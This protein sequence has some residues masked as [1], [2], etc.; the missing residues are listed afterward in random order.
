[1]IKGELM[2][3]EL[4]YCP[5]AQTIMDR[6]AAWWSGGILDRPIVTLGVTQ[7][8]MEMPRKEHDSVRE[9][10]FDY[11]HQIACCEAF[12]RQCVRVGDALPVFF[13]NLGPEVA[14]TLFGADLEFSEESSWAKPIASSCREILDIE[15][16]L[17]SP[18]WQTIRGMVDLSLEA[19]NGK[20]VTAYTD[21]HTNGDL[22][23]SLRDPQ[24]LC[25]ELIDDPEGVRLACEHV[26]DSFATIYDDIWNRIDAYGQPSV[27]WIHAPAWGKMFV[28][29]CDF[30][31]LISKEM[32]EEIVWPSIRREIAC[33]DRNIFHLDGP[34]ALKH[35]DLVLDEPGIEG[36]QW[37]YGAGNGPA[38]KWERVYLEAQER[39]KCLQ[40]ICEDFDDARRLM[41][42]LKPEGV[43]FSIGGLAEEAEARAF[44]DEVAR[45][46]GR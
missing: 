35:L 18:Y 31:A 28:P 46:G 10:W 24:E 40:V 19:G 3:F 14:A 9:R 21:L 2:A 6:Y 20:W 15:C 1:M 43:W 29:N 37:V 27:T 26:T 25:I 32:F 36:L 45:W 17:E 44:L 22:L 30:N 4:E 34:S 23:A 33:C 7:P 5:E 41:K 13:P 39:G 8:P 11:E 42:V 12:Y 16:N 38:S